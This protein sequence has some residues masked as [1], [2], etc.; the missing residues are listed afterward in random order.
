[1]QPETWLLALHPAAIADVE[2]PSSMTRAFLFV[3]RRGYL[4]SV[5]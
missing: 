3:P 5:A 1:L 2:T 4:I